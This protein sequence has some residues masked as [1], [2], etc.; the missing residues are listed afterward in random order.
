MKQILLFVKSVYSVV[1]NNIILLYKN[2]FLRHDFMRFLFIFSVIFFACFS[3]KSQDSINKLDTEGKKQGFWIKKDKDGK[4]FYE[5]QFIHDIPVGEFRYY[6]PGGELK[7]RSVLSDNGNRS[8]VT[9]YFKNGR[10]M[11]E[12]LYINEKKDSIWKFYSEFENVLV[13]E[14]NYKDGKKEGVS[15]TYYP[16]GVVAE[17]LTWKN[18]VRSG[19]WEQYYTDGKIK[20]KCTYLN[21]QKHGQIKGYFSSGRTWL[22]GQYING[23]ADGTWTYKT[24]KGEVEKKEYF[25]KGRLIN[26][27]ELIKKKSE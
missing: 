3:S 7:A 21:D 5:G 22:T 9:T 24:D 1:K 25:N 15:I 2:T 6:Y 23:D 13:S 14:E 8:Q 18:G 16:D 26:T 17:R 10:K 27:E 4:K 20:L 19:L 12:G 11:A